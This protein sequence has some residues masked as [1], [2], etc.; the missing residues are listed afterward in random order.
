MLPLRELPRRS[1]SRLAISVVTTASMT[2][3]GISLP[4]PHRI[5]GLVIRWPT[6]RTKSSARPCSLTGLPSAPVY[7]RSAF[8]R[9][10]IGLPPFSKVSSS[11]PFIRP[12]QLRYTTTL[13]SASTAATESSQ[14]MMVDSAASI[15]RSFTP[16]ASVLP[17]APLRSICT[18]MCRPLF[19]SS[20]ALGAAA[21]PWKPT[22]FSAC[23]RPVVEPF[24]S[25]TTSLPPST[26]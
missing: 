17:M 6:L 1:R 3:S 5:A 23:C 4:S 15:S 18:S 2:P 14:S 7:S 10:V 24:C 9:R 16:A 22:N 26:A 21:S 11:V 25:F 8:R 20:T 13:S 12:S 19:F